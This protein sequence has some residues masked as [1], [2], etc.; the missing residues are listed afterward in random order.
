M[1]PKLKLTYKISQI[2]ISS[3][4]GNGQMTQGGSVL[5]IM[6]EDI[7]PTRLLMLIQKLVKPI[8]LLMNALIHLFITE[9]TLFITQKMEKALFGHQREMAGGIYT[10]LML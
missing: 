5:T 9:G 6:K 4:S 10:L 2:H 1:M 8:L 3:F 7:R